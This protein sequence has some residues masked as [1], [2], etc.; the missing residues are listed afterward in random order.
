MELI[1]FFEDDTRYYL[2]FEK[3][4][5]GTV[6]K[7]CFC[8]L[9]HFDL[10]FKVVIEELTLKC[11]RISREVEEVSYT[12]LK[13]SY[14]EILMGLFMHLQFYLWLSDGNVS[15]IKVAGLKSSQWVTVPSGKGRH[16]GCQ[17]FCMILVQHI[18]SG[19]VF[20]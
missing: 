14:S 13:Y 10:C 20:P 1:E 5:G 6:Q 15:P 8:S 7:L 12:T 17:V 2:V 11:L 3:L 19:R 4:R 9:N 18:Y 16:T